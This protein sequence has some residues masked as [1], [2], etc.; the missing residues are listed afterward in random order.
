MPKMLDAALDYARKGI[1]VFPCDPRTKRPLTP[2]GFK[3]AT[4][5]EKQITLWWKTQYPNTMIA[6][7]TGA[8]SGMLVLDTDV[9]AG[10]DIDGPK[11]LTQ[12]VTKNTPLPKTPTSET[13]RGGTHY[14]FAWT[15]NPI[16]KNSQGKLGRGLDIRGEGGYVALPPSVR[17]DGTPYRWTNGA[18]FSCAKLPDWLIKL[19]T[20]SPRNRAWAKNALEKECAAVAAAP[21]GTRNAALNRA[22][23]NLFQLVAGEALDEDLV[24]VSS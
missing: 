9:D 15:G 7:P 4:T 24:R 5:D 14:F 16:I 19:L 18:D 11:E 10:K 1:P 6:M 12:L 21:P 22:A 13:P 3:D 23:F 20:A 8:A 17:S 2:N